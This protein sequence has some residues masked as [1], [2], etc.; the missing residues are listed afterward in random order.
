MNIRPDQNRL[1]FSA[2]TLKID[3][4]AE[5]DRIVA[6]LRAQLRS[7]QIGRAHV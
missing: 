4:A 6:G 5:A 1:V 3:E 2:D 7:L